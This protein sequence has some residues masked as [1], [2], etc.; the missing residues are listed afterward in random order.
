[1]DHWGVTPDLMTAGKGISS[2]YSPLGAV[3]VNK[4]IDQAFEDTGSDFPHIFTYG[5]NPL[6]AAAGSAVLDILVKERLI[7]RSATMGRYLSKRL[8]EIDDLPIIGD[9]RGKGLLHGV[10]FVKDKSTKAPF[11]REKQISRRMFKGMASRGVLP[12]IGTGTADGTLGD[13]RPMPTIH[14]H[15]GTD[16]RDHRLHRQDRARGSH[17]TLKSRQTS[18]FSSITND[19]TLF[20]PRQ[21]HGR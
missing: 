12:Y 15:R 20:A 10:E 21:Y 3:L 17:P 13:L 9:T 14:H 6:S 2:G 1:L 5:F 19:K 16:R 4:K 7:E 8:K 18:R 11:P